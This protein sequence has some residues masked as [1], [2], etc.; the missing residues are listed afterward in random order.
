[1]EEENMR[2]RMVTW[3]VAVLVAALAGTAAAGHE[4]AIDRDGLKQQAARNKELALYLKHNGYP[5]VAEVRPIVDQ[6]P[7][8]DHEVVLY[9]LGTRKEISFAR[10]RVLG[11][12]DISSTRYERVMTDADIRALR[13]HAAA[14]GAEGNTQVASACTGNAVTR[15]ECAAGR[16]ES[17]AD[18]VDVAATRAEKAADKTEAI[19]EKMMA[20]DTHARH[21]R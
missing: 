14:A 12:T 2:G 16:A 10:A 19:V 3:T 9:Y 6:P 13:T 4:Q 1:M 17:A 11:R 20:R 21:R 15:A 5:D 8:D 7:W 18:R